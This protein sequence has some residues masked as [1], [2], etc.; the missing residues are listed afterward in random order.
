MR[1]YTLQDL[2]RP[3]PII[4]P[5]RHVQSE[6]DPFRKGGPAGGQYSNYCVNLIL[7]RSTSQTKQK[8][9]NLAHNSFLTTS[10]ACE[11]RPFLV[12]LD[13]GISVSVLSSMHRPTVSEPICAG[14]GRAVQERS[15]N[16]MLHIHYDCVCVDTTWQ[17]VAARHQ[18]LR[19]S[20][21]FLP[22]YTLECRPGLGHS[23]AKQDEHCLCLVCWEIFGAK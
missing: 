11:L 22:C 9:E 12:G 10:L 3:T 16:L 13:H 6:C 14:G 21:Y 1:S 8:K 17:E 20:I 18:G 4:K 15:H 2:Y 7:C 23:S 19:P 5:S